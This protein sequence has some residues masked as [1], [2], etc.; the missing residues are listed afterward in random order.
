MNDQAPGWACSDAP[1]KLV[2]RCSH[3]KCASSVTT[4]L[5]KSTEFQPQYHQEE[6]SWHDYRKGDEQMQFPILRCQ[7]KQSETTDQRNQSSGWV[8]AT[9]TSWSPLVSLDRVF[10]GLFSSQHAADKSVQIRRSSL[11][12]H[13]SSHASHSAHAS[14]SSWHLLLFLGDLCNYGLSGR[15]QWCH[16]CSIQQCSPHHLETKKKGH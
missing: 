10:D 4:G 8:S 6:T 11:E 12:T 3:R 7:F 5:I 14:H 15:K 16:S 13:A 1:H 9:A 2:E